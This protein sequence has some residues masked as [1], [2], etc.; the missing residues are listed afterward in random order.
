M[1]CKAQQI[2]DVQID[3]CRHTHY[4]FIAIFSQQQ[5]NA[6]SHSLSFIIHT[7]R[8]KACESHTNLPNAWVYHNQSKC[9]FSFPICRLLSETDVASKCISTSISF[10]YRPLFFVLSTFF[11]HSMYVSLSINPQYAD[12][13]CTHPD[14]TFLFPSNVCNV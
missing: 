13:L 12:I 5:T 11:I 9:I 6:C 10:T 14:E 3:Y 2:R 7:C 4:A 8:R 1:S